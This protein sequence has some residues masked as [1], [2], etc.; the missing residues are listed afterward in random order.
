MM[1]M[2]ELL[3]ERNEQY[4]ER[5]DLAVERL[6]G[7]VS[8]ETVPGRYLLYFQDVAIFLLERPVGPVQLKGNAELK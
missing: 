6:R 5:H 2:T 7:I 1:G 3:R 8:E 4:E